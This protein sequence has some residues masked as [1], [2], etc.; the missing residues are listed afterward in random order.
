MAEAEMGGHPTTWCGKVSQSTWGFP[1][2]LCPQHSNG[3]T[4]SSLCDV[5]SSGCCGEI[6]DVR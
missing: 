1:L 2:W 3:D 5:R 4:A 6:K